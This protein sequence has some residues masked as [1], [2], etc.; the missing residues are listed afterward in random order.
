MMKRSTVQLSHRFSLK[1]VIGS[2]FA[3]GLVASV[4]LPEAVQAQTPEEIE[5]YTTIAKQIE[6]QRMQDYA[7]VKKL[8]GG[9]VPPNICQ[10]GNL[11]QPVQNVCDRFEATSREIITRN[12][13]T[14]A[15]FNE[16]FRF[17]QQS[18]KPKECPK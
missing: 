14:V 9:N 3:F 17:C 4:M 6:R 5:K 7:E 15:K 10:Q 8:M 18:P 12:G 1:A 13:M 11:T 16:I 2:F